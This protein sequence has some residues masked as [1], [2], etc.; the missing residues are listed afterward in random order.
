MRTF[1]VPTRLIFSGAPFRIARASAPKFPREILRSH[2]L[3]SDQR[4]YRLRVS[5]R[6]EWLLHR[7]A[8]ASA[9]PLY[10]RLTDTEDLLALSPL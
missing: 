7:V 2:L 5:R 3:V 4:L 1:G 8:R 9:G 6:C 10:C